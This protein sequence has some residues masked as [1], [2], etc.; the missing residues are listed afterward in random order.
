MTI[1]GC[2]ADTKGFNDV[3]DK[4]VIFSIFEHGLYCA[5]FIILHSDEFG[6]LPP[7]QIVPRLA[8][9]GQYIASESTFYRVLRAELPVKQRHK[10]RALSATAPNQLVSCACPHWYWESIFTCICS[11]IF[12]AAKSL[13][14]KFMIQKAV[15]W[16]ATSCAIFACEK[17]SRRTRLYCIRTTAARWKAQRC[18][19]PC[20]HWVW[21]HHSAARRSVT[22]IHIQ[23][24]YSRRWNTG[25]LIQ[26]KRLKASLPPG[27]GSACLSNGTTMNIVTVPSAL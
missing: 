1:E 13:A 8:D 4:R 7:S 16:P 15:N 10:P 14:G 25:Q 21:H 22:I 6:Q 11:S 23:S 9:C 2:S 20:K 3:G 5:H 19:L 26:A 17:I 24:R 12:L 18:W 27:G